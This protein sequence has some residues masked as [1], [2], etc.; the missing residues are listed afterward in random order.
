VR[1]SWR[2]PRSSSAP[3]RR[4]PRARAAELERQHET[5]RR[6][7]AR[8]RRR[9]QDELR[10][11]LAHGSPNRSRQR[12]AGSASSRGPRSRPT[13]PRTPS[14]HGAAMVHPVRLCGNAAGR[15]GASAPRHRRFTTQTRR[16]SRVRCNPDEHWLT[17]TV[18]GSGQD[19]EEVPV[20]RREARRVERAR[21]VLSDGLSEQATMSASA[22]GS[23]GGP[24]ARAAPATNGASGPGGGPGRDD[25]VR[26][27]AR[28]SRAACATRA[29]ALTRAE[30]APA[31]ESHTCATVSPRSVARSPSTPHRHKE[32]E[33]RA[34]YRTPGWIRSPADRQARSHY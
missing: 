7:R 12:A 15:A 22:N 28:V 18:R 16:P 5:R 27:L 2:C 24:A 20:D 3:T 4:R 34:T 33:Y 21:S 17:R 23:R 31:A 1:T 13:D 30:R 25:S 8:N 14:P 32:R 29:R 19:S 26:F 6:D 11:S 9:R 10:Q